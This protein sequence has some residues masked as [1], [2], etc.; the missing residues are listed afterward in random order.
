MRGKILCPLPAISLCSILAC[1]CIA[2]SLHHKTRECH[3]RRSRAISLETY[4]SLRN[5][6]DPS[7]Q[8]DLERKP[9]Q[10][11]QY[12]NDREGALAN[13][14]CL[15]RLCPNG[16]EGALV[17]SLEHVHRLVILLANETKSGMW[18]DPTKRPSS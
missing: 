4:S 9:S 12:P 13:I 5:P 2:M 7:T 14:P 16:H 11:L 15:I 8:D 1:S 18:D 10:V 3:Q 17:S 6:W